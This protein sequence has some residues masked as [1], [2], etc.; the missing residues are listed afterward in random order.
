MAEAKDCTLTVAATDEHRLVMLQEWAAE[1]KGY[2]H[3]Q[4]SRTRA[5]RRQV[6]AGND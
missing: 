6:S 3:E 4:A 5:A 2:E 1:G